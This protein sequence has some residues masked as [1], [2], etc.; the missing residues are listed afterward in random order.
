MNVDDVRCPECGA[1]VS[2]Q[3]VQPSLELSGF[4]FIS[5]HCVNAHLFCLHQGDG[6]Y[7]LLKAGQSGTDLKTGEP[8][9]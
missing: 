4:E 7:E 2:P 9:P 3:S 8:L 1:G 6:S 5:M